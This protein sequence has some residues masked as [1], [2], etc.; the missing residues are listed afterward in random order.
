[1]CSLHSVAERAEDSSIEPTQAPA[2]NLVGAH[3]GLG[4]R[5]IKSPQGGIESRRPNPCANTNSGSDGFFYLPD[6]LGNSIT[7]SGQNG[8]AKLQLE[9]I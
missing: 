9:M 3:K 2:T 8:C 4:Y 1:M 6:V 5:E 7:D